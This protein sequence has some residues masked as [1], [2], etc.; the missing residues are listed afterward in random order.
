MNEIQPKEVTIERLKKRQ[1]EVDKE[2]KRID[3]LDE[4]PHE[5]F[6]Y[7]EKL[8]EQQTDIKRY[9]GMTPEVFQKYIFEIRNFLFK[10]FPDQP[11][12]NNYGG[13]RKKRKTKKSRKQRRRHTKRRR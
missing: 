6:N 9:L 12:L 5:Y 13:R 8:K 11:T 2:L 3:D 10:G 1:F 4:I 7:I